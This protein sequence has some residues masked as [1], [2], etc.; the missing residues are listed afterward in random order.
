M[1]SMLLRLHVCFKKSRATRPRPLL[2][3]AGQDSHVTCNVYSVEQSL[4]T[5]EYQ[6][7]AHANA[8]TSRDLPTVSAVR[9]PRHST[10]KY[11]PERVDYLHMTFSRHL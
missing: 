2:K 3:L 5:T 7:R 8:M 1:L 4:T 11:I 6:G 9:I 10:Q